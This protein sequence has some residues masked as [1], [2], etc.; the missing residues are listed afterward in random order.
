[1]G[2]EESRIDRLIRRRFGKSIPQSLIERSLRNKYISIDGRKKVLASDKVLDDVEIVIHPELLKVFMKFGQPEDQMSFHDYVVRFKEMIIFE[3]E[4]F[5]A[6]DKPAG[7]AVQLGSKM[8]VAVDVMAKSYNPEARLVHRVDKETSGITLLAK[9][10]STARFMLHSFYNKN[11]EKTYIAMVSGSLPANKFTIDSPLS[12]IRDRV[13]VDLEH[14]KKAVTNFEMIDQFCDISSIYCYPITGRTHQIR[15]H[16]ASVNC[17][18]LGDKKYGHKKYD[19]LCL[20]AKCISFKNSYGK[21][22]TITTNLP[23]YF[24]TKENRDFS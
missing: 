18:I 14:G 22:I 17:P 21:K 24:I 13:V 10:V 5:I 7:L 11:I 12:K 1:M 8:V 9:S 3:D 2:Y 23:K 16:L 20:H 15:V 4:E 6:I 19:F